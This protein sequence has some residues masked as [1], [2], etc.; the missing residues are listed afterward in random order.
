MNK[1][2]MIK[3]YTLDCRD[4]YSV[5]L[6]HIKSVGRHKRIMNCESEETNGEVI[7]IYDLF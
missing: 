6:G 3:G 5:R 1:Y 7:M 2:P 4:F